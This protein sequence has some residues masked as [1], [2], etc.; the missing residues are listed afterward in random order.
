MSECI[1]GIQVVC[2]FLLCFFSILTAPHR[3]G[4]ASPPPVQLAKKQLEQPAAVYSAL[5]TKLLIV[6]SGSSV[7]S[8]VFTA[9]CMS[10]LEDHL[11]LSKS[12]EAGWG[13]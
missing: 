3:S 9:R 5:K 2:F 4:W 8:I 10:E 1:L 6:H 7:L 12:G 13:G 11:E